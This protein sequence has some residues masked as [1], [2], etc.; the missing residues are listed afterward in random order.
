MSEHSQE[1]HAKAERA[2]NQAALIKFLSSRSAEIEASSDPDRSRTGRAKASQGIGTIRRL[3]IL[4]DDPA[5][6]D[7][8]KAKADALEA[9]LNVLQAENFSLATQPASK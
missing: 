5:A 6:V 1:D 4:L 2:K 3:A 9:T 8:I 7:E